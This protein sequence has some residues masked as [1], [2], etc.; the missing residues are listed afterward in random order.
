MIKFLSNTICPSICLILILQSSFLEASAWVRKKGHGFIATGVTTYQ[1]ATYWNNQGV[2]T[3][4]NNFFQ[5]QEFE[6]YIE[7]GLSDKTTITAKGWGA[8]IKETTVQHQSGFEDSELALIHEVFKGEKSVVSLRLLGIIPSGNHS[9]PD[10]RYAEFGGELDIQY[11]RNFKINSKNSF[12][13]YSIGYR[14][15]KSYPS[16]QIRSQITIGVELIDRFQILASSYLEYGV[17]NGWQTTGG[18]AI[19]TN[20]NYRL[21]K[22][23]LLARFAFTKKVS[24]YGGY[25]K[26]VWG[27]NVGTNGGVRAGLWIEY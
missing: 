21:I 17:Y 22:C 14:V 12:L 6:V 11:G 20:P 13:D 15:Y 25:Y 26:D 27:R 5:K 8:H 10:L 7:H 4:A 19:L 9:K 24:V 23:E 3:P 2:R 1:T 16:D 18:N